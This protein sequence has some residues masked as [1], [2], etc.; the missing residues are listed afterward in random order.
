MCLKIVDLYKML[1]KELNIRVCD[2][3]FDNLIKAKKLE[4]KYI[5]IDEKNYKDVVVYFTRYVHNKSIKILSLYYHELMGK[6]R[7]AEG[8]NYLVVDN[9]MLVKVLGKE[10]KI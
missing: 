7:K 10:K 6:I 9:Y 1:I 3:Y 4:T 8:K 2:S 5:L